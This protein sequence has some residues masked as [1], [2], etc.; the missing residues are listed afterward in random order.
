[1][2]KLFAKILTFVTGLFNNLAPKVEKAIHAGVA[3]TEAVKNFVESPVTDLLTALIPGTV[4]DKIKVQLRN[5]LPGVL[6]VMRLIET[7]MEL[8]TPEAITAAA[9]KYIE[10]LSAE[11]KRPVLH[12]LAV[13]LTMI[14][15]DGKITWSEAVQLVEYYYQ[16]KFKPTGV[17]LE[18][19]LAA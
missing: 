14:L 2:K 8:K 3:V 10:S 11:D 16:F 5:S 9:L 6:M 4:D 19:D 13:R 17:Q 18:L 1:M 12:E 7:S 15:A